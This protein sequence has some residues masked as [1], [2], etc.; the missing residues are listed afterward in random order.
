MRLATWGKTW[1]IA[2]AIAFSLFVLV[3]YFFDSPTEE[4][5][6]KENTQLRTQ[7]AILERRLDNSLKVMERLQERDDN[8]YRVMKGMEPM[9]RGQRL[10]GLDNEN[11]YRELEKLNDAGLVT[12]LTQ[13]MD[14]LERQLFAQVQSFNQ[15]REAIGNEQEK[16][17]HIPSVIPIK[18][19]DFIISSG[20]GLRR[21]PINGSTILHEG[22]DLSASSGT[23][24][25]A[26][27]D[28]IIEKADRLAGLGN[29]I[30]ISH[31]FDYCSRYA[32]LD[33]ILVAEGDVVKRGQEIGRV[34]STGASKE[35]H[36][37]YEVIHKEKSQNP[38]NYFFM[39]LTPEQYTEMIRVADNAGMVLD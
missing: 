37:H 21:N 26:T 23:P 25:F 36:L 14:L 2:L 7:Y 30:E 9:S 22:I 38:V 29:C 20:Y 4:N 24:V 11:R 35:P 19:G 13:R 12:R 17:A 39:D 18:A 16:L 34:G 15:L 32:H 8:F 3:F 27:G 31:G 28:G 5:L 33:R 6:R 10:A 1:M